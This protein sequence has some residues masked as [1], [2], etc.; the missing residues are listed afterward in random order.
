MDLDEL[1]NECLTGTID[2]IKFTGSIIANHL[3]CDYYT[4]CEYFIPKEEKDPESLYLQLLADK[5]N[6]HEQNVIA[7][8]FPSAIRNTFDDN[9]RSFKAVLNEM[10]KGTKLLAGFPLYYVPEKYEG[11]I[12]LLR[13]SNNHSSIFGDYHYEIIEIKLAKNIKPKHIIQAIFYNELLGRIQNY[14]PENVYVINGEQKENSHEFK[15]YSNDLTSIIEDIKLIKNGERKP[16]PAYKSC[17]TPW[18]NYNDIQAE[19]ERDI[20]LVPD[21]GKSM[22]KNLENYNILKFDDLRKYDEKFLTQI[23]DIGDKRAKSFKLHAEA[24]AEYKKIIKEPVER[25]ENVIEYFIDFEGVDPTLSPLD[26]ISF[27]FLFGVILKNNLIEKKEFQHFIIKDP[28]NELEMKNVFKNFI[29]YLEKYSDAPVYHWGSYEN[30]RIKKLF[31]IYIPGEDYSG[32]ISRL[33]DLNKLVKYHYA[34]PVYSYSVKAVAKY[35]GFTWRLAEMEG[36]MAIAKYVLY[37]LDEFKEESEID[38][39]INYNED[40]IEALIYIKNTLF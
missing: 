13:R 5:G 25:L 32:F 27:D 31:E 34:L 38:Q 8:L 20:T 24:F 21:I 3:V 37:I 23:K 6:Q 30:T 29:Q 7:N 14:Y 33:N 40:D 10:L 4:Y 9:I 18:S 22:Q 17:Q 28:F 16:R 19:K 12:D 2:D 39:I 26:G 35:L 11:H 15:K 36:R 1:I